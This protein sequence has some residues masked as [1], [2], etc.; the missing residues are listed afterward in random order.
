M[1]TW[2][3]TQVQ[4]H[5]QTSK[6]TCAMETLRSPCGGNCRDIVAYNKVS[7]EPTDLD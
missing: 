1:M 5:T 2:L 4:A 6:E 7:A 3:L